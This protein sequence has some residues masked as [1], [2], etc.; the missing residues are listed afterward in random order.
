MNMKKKASY[1]KKQYDCIIIGSA[2]AGMTSAISLSKKGFKNILILEKKNLPGGVTTSF[3]RDKNEFEL[4]LHEM[5]SI[6]SSEYPLGVRKFLEENG[7]YASWKRID[8]AFTY[9]EPG[10]QCTIHAGIDGDINRPIEDIV[11]A[12]DGDNELREK[13]TLFFSDCKNVYD[14]ITSLSDGNIFS[15]DN[16]PLYMDM[17][18]SISY[19]VDEVLSVY[20]FPDKVK[21]ILTAYWAYLGNSPDEL[22]F[23]L[24]CFMIV[25]YFC[26]S[27]YLLEKTSHDLSMRMLKACEDLGIQIEFDCEVKNILVE[28]DRCIGVTFFDDSAVYSNYIIS[29][30]YPQSVYT[31]MIKSNKPLKKD[32]FKFL[33][34]K[35]LSMTVFSIIMLLDCPPSELPSDKYMTFV[36]PEG[37]DFKSIIKS[38]HS[39]NPF[40]Y[41]TSVNM[42]VSNPTCCKEG[43]TMY[44]ITVLPYTD[45]FKKLTKKNYDEIK[46]KIA[47]KLIDMESERIGF[48]FKDHIEEIEFITP[49][50]ISRYCNSFRG[51]IYGF[52]PSYDDN[53]VARI[54]TH[55]KENFIK[56]LFFAG[57]HSY[58]GDGMAPQITNGIQAANDV[59]NQFKNDVPKTLAKIILNK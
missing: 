46:H 15:L 22:P 20:Q 48:D 56:G 58:A 51:C 1:F 14:A 21:R 34:S 5:C 13:L 18:R 52:L 11:S 42:N 57:A 7:I 6:G 12:C 33:N 29:G 35:K 3:M 32:I 8:Q 36:A 40:K 24:F 2:L 26:Y 37:L 53:I 17:L 45:A 28:N 30:A 49:V 9:V 10:F 55:Q 38:Y 54:M 59:Y 41:Y 16:F 31:R 44:S 25:D 27:P 50:S 4:S 43:K 23:I 39:S 47:S 19:S